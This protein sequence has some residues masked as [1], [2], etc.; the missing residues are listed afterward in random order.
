MKTL[1][2]ERLILRDWRIEDAA[3]MLAFYR[4]PEIW[5][6]A[7]GCVVSDLAVCRQ[8]IRD[9]GEAQEVWAVVLQ[10]SGRAVGS[11]FLEDIGRHRDYRE[12]EFVL[13]GDCHNRGYMTEAVRRVLRFAFTELGLE[14]VAACHYPDNVQSRRVL[15]KCGFSYEGTLRKYSKNGKDSV[16]Y[17]ITKEEWLKNQEAAV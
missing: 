17:S 4:D 11:I 6:R 10:G 5:P 16:R 12:L 14:I 1:T 2:T 15:E 3:D 7:G 8:C 9:Y 13:S